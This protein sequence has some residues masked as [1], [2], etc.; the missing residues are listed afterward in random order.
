MYFLTH[1]P[2]ENGKHF[3]EYILK[4]ILINENFCFCACNGVAPN[5][6]Q[7]ITWTN[8]DPVYRRIYA[9]LGRDDLIP[10]VFNVVCLRAD[11]LSCLTASYTINIYAIQAQSA[12][13][14][15]PPTPSAPNPQPQ[16][17]TPTPHPHPTRP[18][19]PTPEKM[20]AISQTTFWNAFSWMK[21]KNRIS[22]KFVPKGPINNIPALV[23]F[24][25]YFKYIYTGWTIQLH[26][27]SMVPC[28]KVKYINI[29][30]TYIH[31]HKY[32]S[33]IKASTSW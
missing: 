1:C 4:C 18:P 14:P 21:K 15:P 30:N 2:L 13:P 16:P 25:F 5:R 9:A 28:Y 33:Y 31:I 10:S 29:R 32:K 17:P 23:L 22:L 20:A 3:T 7:V 26:C 11:T 8:D 6:Q 19:P 24:L 12:T 27:S